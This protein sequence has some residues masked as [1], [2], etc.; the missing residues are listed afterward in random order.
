MYFT[1]DNTTGATTPVLAALAQAAA[2]YYPA[3]GKDAL[4]QEIKEVFARIFEHEVSVFP[5]ATG[6]A[7]NALS[8]AAAVPPWGMCLCHHKAHIMEDECGAPEFFMHGGK[9]CGLEGVGGK[10]APDTLREFLEQLPQSVNQTPATAISLTQATEYGTIYRP[11]E[12]AEIAAIAKQH[13]LYVHMDGARFA[14][15]L[16]SL[17]CTP[18]ELTWKQGVD[19]L[20]FGAT[21]NGC[22]MA[23]A[24]VVFNP[25]LAETLA[26]RRKRAGQTLSKNWLIAAQFKAYFADNHWLENAKHANDMA[27]LLL[28]QV[29]TVPSVRAAWPTEAN[30]VFILIPNLM[31]E[32]LRKAG[33]HYYDW[34]KTGLPEGVEL[35]EN[36]TL[37]RLVTSFATQEKDIHQFVQVMQDAALKNKVTIPLAYAQG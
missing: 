15:A 7:A 27:Q 33:A 8:L 28:Q 16:V 36:D 10:L 13:K 4:T 3:Y 30:E 35:R 9:L 21:K 26:Y 23:E 11:E 31:D 34:P 37:I 22:L 5:V 12:I 25:L 1:S 20:S 14:N 6:T 18:A 29:L 17:G 19:I 2:G 32:A 24:I